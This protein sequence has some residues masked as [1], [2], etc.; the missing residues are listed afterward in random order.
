MKDGKTPRRGTGGA[1]TV[2][3]HNCYKQRLLPQ[4][5]QV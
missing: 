1:F 5:S 2:K 4:A 3:Y